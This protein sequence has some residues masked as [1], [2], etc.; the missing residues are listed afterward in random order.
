MAH[1]QPAQLVGQ[2][3]ASAV[4]QVGRSWPGTLQQIFQAGQHSIPQQRRSLGQMGPITAQGAATHWP[5]SQSGCA[6]PQGASQAPQCR[7]SLA[8]STQTPAHEE[9]APVA[10]PAPLVVAPV[11]EP[12][13]ELELWAP[14]EEEV[15]E[16]PAQAT[17][18]RDEARSVRAGARTAPSLA[19]RGRACG[20]QPAFLTAL[21]ASLITTSSRMRSLAMPG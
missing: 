4:T 2:A 3:P 10:P 11:E 9:H 8:R 13:P 6:P 15:E 14:L 5:R 7:G 16:L 19:Q 12:P 18:R 17:A 20:D 1:S 21:I